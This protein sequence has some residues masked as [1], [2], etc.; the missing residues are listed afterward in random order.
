MKKRHTYMVLI[1]IL[2]FFTLNACSARNGGF[3]DGYYTAIESDF[4]SRGWKEF[5]TMHVSN[6]S[7][8]SL[9]YNAKN[10]SGMIKSWDMNYMRTMNRVAGTYPNAFTRFYA[11]AFMRYQ[12]LE[13]VD[14]M[15]GATDS[16]HI[17][18]ALME[19]A[20]ELAEAGTDGVVIIDTSHLHM[21]E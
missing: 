7:V 4:C 8:I 5:V 10:A 21:Q 1:W 20:L 14:V 13:D 9:E 17:F 16:F 15:T 19:A 11:N 6:G 12:D 18:N 3:A 2:A